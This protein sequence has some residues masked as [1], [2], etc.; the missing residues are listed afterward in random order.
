MNIEVAIVLQA[1]MR[2]GFLPDSL[3]LTMIVPIP[4][5]KNGDI[6]SKGNYRPIAIA[7]VISKILEICIQ[8]RLQE[9]LWTTDNQFAY[10]KA[11]QQICVFYTQGN[12]SIL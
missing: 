3:M 7:T 11:I 6:T 5:S 2:H 10:K 8:K 4:K 1:F 9:Y 12:D